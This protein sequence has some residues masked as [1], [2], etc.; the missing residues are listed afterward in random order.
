MQRYQVDGTFARAHGQVPRAL[1]GTLS[2]IPGPARHLATC[3]ASLFLV[4]LLLISRRVLSGAR[5]A[6]RRHAA[7]QPNQQKCSDSNSGL[8]NESPLTSNSTPNDVFNSRG[9]QQSRCP[10]Q[11]AENIPPFGKIEIETEKPGCH[12]QPGFRAPGDNNSRRQAIYFL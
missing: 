12:A 3:A 2:D 11:L 5:L 8:H 1:R 7:G 4:M 10:K 9:R 6:E